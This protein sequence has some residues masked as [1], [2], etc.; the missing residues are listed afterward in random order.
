MTHGD[1]SANANP[2][3]LIGSLYVIMMVTTAAEQSDLCAVADPH[4]HERIS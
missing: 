2:A 1:L 4:L 3:D